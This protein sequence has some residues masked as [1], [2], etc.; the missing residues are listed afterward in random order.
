MN[1]TK[2]CAFTFGLLSIALM[3]AQGA[4]A[5]THPAGQQDPELQLMAIRQAIAGA[6]EQ[7]P[8]RVLSTAWID[9]SGR[10]HETTVYNTDTEVRGVRVLAY[11]NDGQESREQQISRLAADVNLPHYLK[12]PTAAETCSE[13]TTLQRMPVALSYTVR[14]GSGELD[15]SVAAWL[16]QEA[17]Q[18]NTDLS[19]QSAR[20]YAEASSRV[21]A[22]HANA[23]Y[24]SSLLGSVR[25][26][27]DW[28]LHVHLSRIN[29]PL[30]AAGS[31]Q[32]ETPT[33]LRNWF[34]PREPEQWML[35]LSLALSGQAPVWQWQKRLENEPRE[36]AHAAVDVL[37]KLKEQLTQAI[38]D[39]DRQTACVPVQYTLKP[40]DTSKKTE[41][42][43]TAGERSR[44]KAGDRL[45]VLD[46][47]SVPARLIEPQTM[48]RIAL[49]EVVKVGPRQTELRQLAGAPLPTEGQWV[50]MPL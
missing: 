37:K 28:Q 4:I 42:V 17:T 31:N 47:Q 13:H 2:F 36:N 7:A 30:R 16:K 40:I 29:S 39:L 41:W 43:L 38:R 45:L 22:P 12:A 1:M 33:F 21:G 20:W 27:T 9:A 23:A 35:E 15:A 18:L 46:K 25:E 3:A 10:L 34:S 44:L 26:S 19:A 24:L 49:A 6:I 8:T 32:G 48:Q 11:I 5:Q 14:T 50:A